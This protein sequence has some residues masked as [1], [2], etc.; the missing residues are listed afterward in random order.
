MM[1]QA[2]M[3]DLPANP[4]RTGRSG[5]R[6]H[7]PRGLPQPSGGMTGGGYDRRDRR[8]SIQTI[9]AATLALCALIVLS[10]DFAH[11][12][13][14]VSSV[15]QNLSRRLLVDDSSTSELIPVSGVRT[16][17]FFVLVEPH[18]KHN[19]KMNAHFSP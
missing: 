12:P 11:L 3:E 17:T 13:T 7:R 15:S 1:H 19:N 4:S 18:L 5:S 14:L 9:T 8:R 6:R 10:G 2:K 16:A